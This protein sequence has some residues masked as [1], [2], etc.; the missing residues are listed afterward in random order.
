MS[1]S[2]EN[3]E[4]CKLR[5]YERNNYFYGKLM[6]VRDFELEQQYFNDKRWLIN[7][8]LFGSGTVCGLYVELSGMNVN[9]SSGL[10]ID[11][12]GREIV[13]PDNVNITLSENDKPSSEKKKKAI[14]LYYKECP[15]ERVRAQTAST[16]EEVC[17][18]NRTEE[19]YTYDIRD[20]QAGEES[21][22]ELC[23]IWSNHTTKSSDYLSGNVQIRIKRTA[24]R[25]VSRGDLFEI[26]LEITNLQDPKTNPQS[27]SVSIK[28]TGPLGTLPPG[29]SLVDGNN[30]LGTISIPPG[31]TVKRFYVV[32]VDTSA[33]GNFTIIANING[34][35]VTETASVIELKS[36]LEI[37]ES[38][39]KELA[40]FWTFKNPCFGGNND[41]GVKIAELR[42]GTDGENP[43]VVDNTKRKFVNNNKYMTRMLECLK[44]KTGTL[45]DQSVSIKKKIAPSKILLSP[46]LT[47]IEANG[48]ATSEI[49]ITVQD[50]A[51]V[52][53]SGID[54]NL[55]STLGT[56]PNHVT[57]DQNGVATANLKSG[58]IPGDA[59]VM[60]TT[61]VGVAVTQVTF[62]PT[63]GIVYGTIT[64]KTN[65]TPI[66]GAIVAIGTTTTKTDSKGAYELLNVPH[67]D[68][69]IWAIHTKYNEATAVV[70]V[71]PTPQ[72]NLMDI[73]LTPIPTTG[74]IKGRVTDKDGKVIEKGATVTAG[75]ITE[76]TDE[77][78]KYE[79]SNVPTGTHTVTASAEGYQ[80]ANRASVEVKPDDITSDIDF[81]LEPATGTIRGRVTAISLTGTGGKLVSGRVGLPE[82]TGRMILPDVLTPILAG[83]GIEG[84]TVSVVGTS[85]SAQTD[86]L[87]NYIIYNVPLGTQTVTATAQ[88]YNAGTKSAVV[89]A[90]QTVT[91][92]FQLTPLVTAGT[93]TGRVTTLRGQTIST[94]TA[95]IPAVIRGPV[96]TSI[97]RPVDTSII[98]PVDTPIIRPVDTSI[99]RP[100]DTSIARSIAVPIS[101]IAGAPNA[102]CPA[103]SPTNIPCL[104][105][106]PGTPQ[107]DI[108]IAGATV[109]VDGTSLSAVTD[110]SGYYTI[111]NVPEGGYNVTASAP[112]Y[113]TLT[114]SVTVEAGKIA[115]A[116]FQLTP[117]V[118]TGTISGKVTVAGTQCMA[119][120]PGLICLSSGPDVPVSL[121]AIPTVPIIRNE[122][123]LICPA[124][125]PRA[126]TPGV[127]LK[128]ATISVAGTSL[129]AV[130]DDA[131]NY[132]IP[133]VP[134]NT[135]TV[136]ASAA[137]YNTGTQ[138]ATVNEN[139]T[140]AVNFQLTPLP[141]T[142]DITG[143]VTDTDG[144][145]ISAATVKLVEEDASVIT[146][147]NG[148][149]RHSNVSAGAHTVTASAPRY[150]DYTQRVTVAADQTVTAN[151]IL[152][153][154]ICPAGQPDT[155]CTMGGANNPCPEGQPNTPCP[156][157]R[158]N[159]PCPAGQANTPCQMGGPNNPCPAGQPDTP[160][161]MGGA[162]NPCPEGQP[163]T[164]CPMGRANNPC[165]AGQ[166]NTPCPVGGPNNP[167]I[168]GQPF[169][170]CPAGEPNTDCK[171]GAPNVDCTAGNPDICRAGQP[172]SCLAGKPG[173]TTCTAGQ[174]GVPR[175]IGIPNSELKMA[176]VKAKENTLCPAGRPTIAP[177]TEGVAPETTVKAPCSAGRPTISPK[178]A[179][180]PQVKAK[181]GKK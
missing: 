56:I 58:I 91:L 163:N 174:P 51:G 142:G 37:S 121:S 96:D 98:R 124:G 39:L 18:N 44:A 135:Y 165:P 126:T 9:I 19:S 59:T 28:D 140:T 73:P 150:R 115:T 139:Q 49:K 17:A 34:T 157:G 84:A 11:R 133:N 2:Q 36:P 94:C 147:A 35:Q 50:D 82:I 158:A 99:I 144:T 20:V 90:N 141:T 110:D 75:G 119:G 21:D 33:T 123:A 105:G 175:C 149:Y 25:F 171:A 113:N 30:D 15:K 83:T 95:A 70:E 127:G 107:D 145:P 46:S 67:G 43:L 101:C 88:D 103:G 138:R 134:V 152:S 42:V 100:V 179:T 102:P 76:R 4:N 63:T 176:N 164:P 79:L 156:M 136:T 155:P 62:N 40:D 116:N 111:P 92:D 154:M 106:V 8:L 109:S 14:Y 151:F 125:G 137:G 16:C 53:L 47:E 118:I 97:V 122:T 166:A 71:F 87:G 24:K 54:V 131:G 60:A 57:T 55:I 38:L 72:R 153:K 78:G 162:N 172:D 170:A 132:T 29:L 68:Q 130:T 148:D 65:D 3:N 85:L 74:T 31:W 48:N 5:A 52:G 146:D 181:G 180:R 161:T 108:G 45:E 167:C 7:S 86:K 117:A 177:V 22:E 168:A 61:G 159:N 32:K 6:T 160:C 173:N 178:N 27:T 120:E 10:A 104:T 80:T 1:D 77:D 13:L 41:T 12:C 114:Q 64:D 169:T 112:K 81:K 23:G 66:E 69:V 93:I 143:R 89:E 129:T 26:F 128:G